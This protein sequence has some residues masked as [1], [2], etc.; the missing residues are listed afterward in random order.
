M[1][2]PN[3]RDYEQYERLTD[4]SPLPTAS[5]ATH[6][7]ARQRPGYQRVASV[8][9]NESPTTR[10]ITDTAA[11][12]DIR[13]VSDHNHGLG[14]SSES[15]RAN[16]SSMSPL[17]HESYNNMQTIPDN[18]EPVFSAPSTAAMSGST[19]FDDSFNTSY[20]S[21][22]MHQDSRTSLQSGHAP[23]LYA[24]SDAGLLSV[25][26]KYNDFTPHQNCQSHKTHKRGRC[27][28]V[29]ATII[30]LAVFS[31]VFSAF[32]LGIALKKPRY[33]RYI[34]T[35]GS[36]TPS[37]AAFLTSLFAKLIELSFVTVVVAFIGQ[38]LA[39]RAFKLERAR[40]VT[41][42][43]MSMRTWVMQPGVM[44]TNWESVRYAGISIL[45]V[46]AFLA[47][48]LGILYTSAATALVQ[49]QLVLPKFSSMVSISRHTGLSNNQLP[50]IGILAMPSNWT[51]DSLETH[52]ACRRRARR[53]CFN[54][55]VLSCRGVGNRVDRILG[56]NNQKT[57][58]I[59]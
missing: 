56:P 6:L 7:A 36:L 53:E 48:L 24:K 42:A 9:F 10:D 55:L 59:R 58:D 44:V 46:I 41:L 35:G 21:Q 54:A 39:R 37:S 19:R 12:E 27:S 8:S 38:A 23:S 15:S 49:P 1:A 22:R 13:S 34:R 57:I 30:F 40:G 51:A 3:T 2:S 20:K 18:G 52:R 50:R 11:H 17:Q 43:E 33:G 31:T 4:A 16:R 5:P 28:W 29:P 47:A 25:R 14:I 45:G 32:F 26:S